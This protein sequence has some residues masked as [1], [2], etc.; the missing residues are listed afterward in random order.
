MA[1]PNGTKEI[2]INPTVLVDE[3][4]TFITVDGSVTHGISEEKLEE[5]TNFIKWYD[6]EQNK[7][8]QGQGWQKLLDDI[9]QKDKLIAQQAAH[10]KAL[11]ELAEDDEDDKIEKARQDLEVEFD[12]SCD[13]P[14]YE[15][16]DAVSTIIEITLEQIHAADMVN[17]VNTVMSV[18]RILRYIREKKGGIQP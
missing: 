2:T 1:T 18:Y 13:Y 4:R 6:N 12:H 14:L 3:I 7:L 9:V 11:T 16:E 10:I 8:I 5:F 15:I 17:K